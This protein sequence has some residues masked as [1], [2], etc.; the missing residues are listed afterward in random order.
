[1]KG[2]FD[3]QG[4][5]HHMPRPKRTP[6]SGPSEN[7][8]EAAQRI[9]KSSAEESSNRFVGDGLDG[10]A[11]PKGSRDRS[12]TADS[13]NL[14]ESSIIYDAQFKNI[15]RLTWLPWVGHNYSGRPA[16]RR[17]L[18]VGESH[19]F[20]EE[21]R[22]RV[23]FTRQEISGSKAYTRCIVSEGLVERKWSNR[24]LDA[25]PKLLFG[26]N[27]TDRAR[28]WSDSSF[29]NFVQTPMD[30]KLPGGP[31]RPAWEDFVTG[32]QVFES[33]VSIIQPSHCVFIGVAAANAF[34]RSMASRNI[35]FGNAVLTERVGRTW[36]RFATCQLNA[37]TIELIFVQHLGKFFRWAEWHEYLKRRHP[38][39]M[40]W[41]RA[42]CYTTARIE[43]DHPPRKFSTTNLSSG[44]GDNSDVTGGAPEGVP[45]RFNSDD[46]LGGKIVYVKK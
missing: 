8:K 7:P 28:L 39:M 37:A 3:E 40:G 6:A 29:Y 5:I 31:Q 42:E 18:V 36:G 13:L 30:Y 16:D 23:E 43:G 34:D 24:T 22:E 11:E 38:D 41:L 25:L 27:N 2:S 32:W 35:P 4:A 20:T 15:P 26:T 9:Q 45:T 17:L 12:E 14:G 44:G 10:H 19:Y 33:V 46:E 21:K 1:M